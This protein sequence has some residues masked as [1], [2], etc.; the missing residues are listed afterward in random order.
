MHKFEG[1]VGNSN[2]FN[3]MYFLSFFQQDPIY[4]KVIRTLKNRFEGL[5]LHYTYHVRVSDSI[6]ADNS[7][8]LDVKWSADMVIQDSTVIGISS[9][10]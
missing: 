6:F 3:G 1:D 4:L 10:S 8:S 5:R 2:G 9:R 7:L